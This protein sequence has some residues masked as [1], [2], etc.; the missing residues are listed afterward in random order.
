M[1]GAPCRLP[2]LGARLTM[3][4]GQVSLPLPLRISQAAEALP[5][6]LHL[7]HIVP[8]TPSSLVPS[9]PSR[10]IFVTTVTLILYERLLKRGGCAVQPT[11]S[12]T[13]VH[14]AEIPLAD[15]CDEGPLS[16]ERTAS[17]GFASLPAPSIAPST[18]A[19]SSLTS[20]LKRKLSPS[21]SSAP[22]CSRSSLRASSA[23]PSLSLAPHATHILPLSLP[24]APSALGQTFRLP[25]LE[26]EYVLS[27]SLSGRG[28]G[29]PK[30][31]GISVGRLPVQVVAGDEGANAQEELTD[32][33]QQA[34][35]EEEEP[36]KRR[37][38]E[39]LP[40]YQEFAEDTAAAAA[41]QGRKL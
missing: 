1:R 38:R 2:S 21:A 6:I 25:H 16:R 9:S 11:M 24:L 7:S 19:S 39:K 35:E 18:T 23:P 17:S 34:R 40:F 20:R 3:W 12:L 13:E 29:G 14:R 8:T 36:R 10:P 33:V 37:T 15:N 27:I 31:Q 4:T 5:F 32:D 30:G 22:V 41:A 26:R 28:F